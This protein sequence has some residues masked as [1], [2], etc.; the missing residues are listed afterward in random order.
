MTELEKHLMDGLQRLADQYAADML[1]VQQ[2][3]EKLSTQVQ[4]LAKQLAQQ[5]EQVLS[6]AKLLHGLSDQ[7]DGLT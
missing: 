2:Q 3:N 5:N 6:L 4:A 1:R 7:L